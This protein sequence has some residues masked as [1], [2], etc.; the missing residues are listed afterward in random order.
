MAVAKTKRQRAADVLFRERPGPLAQFLLQISPIFGYLL[1]HRF[2][3]DALTYS[4]GEGMSHEQ[5]LINLGLL[6]PWFT[7]IAVITTCQNNGYLGRSTSLADDLLGMFRS[8]MF[9]SLPILFA[10]MTVA[11]VKLG[12]SLALMVKFSGFLLV[13]IMMSITFVILSIHHLW[14]FWFFGSLLYILLLVAVPS[15]LFAAPIVTLIYGLVVIRTARTLPFKL[16]IG[17]EL[18]AGIFGLCLGS[19]L[20]LDKILWWLAGSLLM[21][22]GSIFLLIIPGVLLAAAYFAFFARPINRRVEQLYESSGKLSAAA[23]FGE[24]TKL[25][26]YFQDVTLGLFAL[27]LLL[28]L[29][30]IGLMELASIDYG[31]RH[32]FWLGTILCQSLALV[33]ALILST[34]LGQKAVVRIAW[35][36]CAALGLLFLVLSGPFMLPLQL[37]L[38]AVLMLSFWSQCRKSFTHPIELAFVHNIQNPS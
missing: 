29:L 28:F 3:H 18:D 20:W 26:R 16:T 22:S 12:W 38:A 2:G 15:T 13:N 10:L 24:V 37:G 21:H 33:F 9:Y 6:L 34:V 4:F 14:R 8:L 17:S 25:K 5:A 19:I 30:V 31:L 32:F 11:V 27:A 35:P 23:Y 7:Q 36:Y 1:F